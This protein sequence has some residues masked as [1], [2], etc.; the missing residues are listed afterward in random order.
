M[1]SG[2]NNFN[3]FPEIKLTKLANCCAVYTYANLENLSGE[4]GEGGLGPLDPL[5]YAT[6]FAH[7]HTVV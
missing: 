5:G 3:Y 4:L 2:G 7:L 6:A 1:I